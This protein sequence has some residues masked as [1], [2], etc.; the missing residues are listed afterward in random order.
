MGI[1]GAFSSVLT[2]FNAGM[3]D[4][5]VHDPEVEACPSCFGL[6]WGVEGKAERRRGVPFMASFEIYFDLERSQI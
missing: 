4:G 1:N 5:E 3:M 6:L 2:D